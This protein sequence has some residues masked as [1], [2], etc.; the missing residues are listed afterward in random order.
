M[1]EPVVERY[2]RVGDER[3]RPRQILRAPECQVEVV[4]QNKE[5]IRLRSGGASAQEGAE[6]EEGTSRGAS[7]LGSRVHGELRCPRPSHGASDQSFSRGRTKNLEI[8]F[9]LNVT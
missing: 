1:D 8:F 4:G 5:D 3:L 7:T 2:P 6:E 9:N